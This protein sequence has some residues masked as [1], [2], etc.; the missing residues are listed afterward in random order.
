M[1]D[2][3]PSARYLGPALRV[4]MLLDKTT[5]AEAALAGTASDDIVLVGGQSRASQPLRLLEALVATTAHDLTIV[6]AN[7]DNDSIQALIAAGRCK[8]LITARLGKLSADRASAEKLEI[9]VCPLGIL[10]ERVRAGGAGLGGILAPLGLAA[11]LGDAPTKLAVGKQEYAVAPAIVG[12]LAL[13]KAWRGDR[14]G[15]LSYRG[16][17]VSSNPLVASAAPLVLAQVDELYEIGD[18]DPRAVDTPGI[19]IRGVIRGN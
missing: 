10:F 4:P 8:K 12:N 14:Y 18:I 13:V 11:G 9:Q 3:E 15:N 19:T 5:S 17:L 7:A 16:A 1:A 6:C 2:S